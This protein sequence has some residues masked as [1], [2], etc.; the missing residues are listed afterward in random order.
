MKLA[1]KHWVSTLWKDQAMAIMLPFSWVPP[2]CHRS[3]CFFLQDGSDAPSSIPGLR[4][5]VSTSFLFCWVLFLRT[6]QPLPAVCQAT[7]GPAAASRPPPA[8][9]QPSMTTISGV[10]CADLPRSP[11][12]SPTPAVLPVQY[13]VCLVPL[14]LSVLLPATGPVAGAISLG[15]HSSALSVL[16]SPLISPELSRLLAL[17][18]LL[19]G[20]F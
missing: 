13:S 12:I 11:L 17:L 10:T 9:Q 15:S 4:I 5:C 2:P 3:L 8:G 14:V 16:P 6:L 20:N 19:L 7:S 18:H 1:S